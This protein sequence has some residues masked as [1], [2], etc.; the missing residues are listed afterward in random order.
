SEQAGHLS[1]DLQRTKV[2]NRKHSDMTI[3]PRDSPC[4]E[5]HDEKYDKDDARTISPRRGSGE[6][7]IIY[8][9]LEKL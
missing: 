1:N 2:R 4:I 5:I 6:I 8:N 9:K 3:I 7:E